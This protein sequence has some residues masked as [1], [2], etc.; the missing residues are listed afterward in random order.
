MLSR[1]G[2]DRSGDDVVGHAVGTRLSPTVPTLVRLS[3]SRTGIPEGESL[4]LAAQV[5]TL[6]SADVATGEVTFLVDGERAGS[7]ALDGSGQAVLDGVLLE[8][9]LHAVVAAYGGDAA[10]AAAT[11]AP[12][13]QAVTAPAL[14]VVVLVAQP[15]EADGVFVCEAEVVDPQSGRLAEGA[16]GELVFTAG[17]MT[18]GTAPLVAGAARLEVAR[19]PRGVV[20]AVFAGDREHAPATGSALV[21][22]YPEG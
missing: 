6:G 4:A 7:A 20:R 11:S 14:P 12:L 17:R 13:P 10:H 21:D 8:V 19:R 22:P 5:V 3:S 16:S 9:G 1:A 15:A 2:D 18:L